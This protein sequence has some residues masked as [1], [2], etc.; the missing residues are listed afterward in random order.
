VLA[1]YLVKI[2]PTNKE[3]KDLGE[4]LNDIKSTETEESLISDGDRKSE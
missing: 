4:K 1:I 3:I 2:I